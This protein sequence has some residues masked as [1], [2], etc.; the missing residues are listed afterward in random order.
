MCIS[1]R[2]IFSQKRSSQNVR[3]SLALCVNHM[4]RLLY[5]G[6]A[7]AMTE[8]ENGDPPMGCVSGLLSGFGA[9]Q[10]FADLLVEMGGT[11]DDCEY[12]LELNS[13]FSLVSESN[14]SLKYSGGQIMVY[15]ELEEALV[16]VVG[17]PYPEYG[18]L[19]PEHV[20]RYENQFKN[21]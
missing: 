7:L 14:Q 4:Y 8:L 2:F 12:R 15:P 13:K 10:G 3:V 6:T 9:I 21:T 18:E 1:L 19:F 20:K 11:D 17:I 16:D 5:N